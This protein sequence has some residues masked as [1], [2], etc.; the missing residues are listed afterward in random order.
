MKHSCVVLVVIVSC[1]AGCA[2]TTT[3]ID[4]MPQSVPQEG[5]ISFTK[6]TQDA[7]VV[8]GPVTRKTAEG[9]FFYW[10]VQSFSLTKEKIV[11]LGRKNQKDNV[12]IRDLTGGRSVQQRT[13]SEDISD[14]SIAPDGKNIVFADNRVGNKNI[15]MIATESGFATRQITN[16]NAA[17]DYP[18]FSPDNSKI[19]FVQEYSD[20]SEYRRYLWTH[21]LNNDALTQYVEGFAPSFTPDGK[22]IVATRRNR[23]NGHREIWLIDLEKGQ[24]FLILSSQDQS[25]F[26]AS[27]SPDGKKLAV[28]AGSSG[29]I[30]QTN[31]DIFFVN[32]DGTGLTQITF[33]PGQDICPR[34]SPDGLSLYFV[35]QRGTADG[36]YNIW[37]M[38][39]K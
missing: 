38:N 33:H 29:K 32:I 4:Y 23:E 13:F 8:L 17:E 2:T 20:G 35:S 10:P 5:G 11:F 16:S 39:L 15:Y 1:L 27:V 18:V 21:D 12:F 28:V 37:R 6:I 19:L 22:K 25:F 14:P 3:T 31:A 30:I 9:R 7:D 34:W 24:E 36:N 26:E